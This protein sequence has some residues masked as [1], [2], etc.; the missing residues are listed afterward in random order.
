MRVENQHTNESAAKRGILAGAFLALIEVAGGLLSNSLG[1]LSSSLNTLI[2]FISSIIMFIAVKE[3]SKPP[4]EKHMYGHEKFE[5]TA[6]IIEALLLLLSCSWIVYH[7]VERLMTG[8]RGIELFWLALGVN[9]V[10]IGIDGFAYLDLRASS[11]RRRSEAIQVGAFHFLTDL[12]IAVTVIA[13]LILYKFGLWFADSAAALCIVTYIALQSFKAMKES[14]DTLTDAAPKGLSEEIE[15]RILT[16]R[17]VE[18]CHRLRVRRA[19]S[20]FFV[21]AHVKLSGGM[22]LY[23]AHL[24]ASQI[25][26]K[27]SK[28][29]PDSDILIHTEPHIG[30]DL[31]TMIRSISSEISGIRNIHNIILRNVS[32]KLSIS[33]HVEI[34]PEVLIS[35][36]HKISSR[37]EEQIRNKIKSVD[38]VI[39]HLEPASEDSESVYRLESANLLQRK[40]V[41]IGETIPGV[42]LLHNI[43]LL[44]RNGKYSVSL[45]CTVDPSFSLK[46]AHEIATKIENKIRTLDEKIDQI[47]VH[48]EPEVSS[49]A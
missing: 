5:S 46:R 19:G 3:S 40:I 31:T 24:I 38:S 28:V 49:S 37:L 9:F 30:E 25:E 8:W 15:K 48:C 41:E 10:S 4:D 6:A 33:C 43:Q 26:N 44:W 36:A 11:K 34:D 12:L 32:G 2:D 17:G 13:G 18:G 27:I 47:D 14:F 7:A 22:P 42:I 45:H 23:Q 20:K 35:Q 29:L 1:L 39:T 21:D 16:V